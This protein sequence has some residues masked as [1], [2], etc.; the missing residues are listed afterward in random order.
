MLVSRTRHALL[1]ALSYGLAASPAFAQ[2]AQTAKASAP[3]NTTAPNTTAPNTTAPN[4]PTT[5]TA[6]AA[7]L[8]QTKAPQVQ[9]LQLASLLSP[10]LEQVQK[11]FESS[12]QDKIDRV[13]GKEAEIAVAV[14]ITEK[15][16][17][18]T[19]EEGASRSP[20][21]TTG[22]RDLPDSVDYGY[23]EI[24]LPSDDP[25]FAE[26]FDEPENAR[27]RNSAKNTEQA[28]E[29]E[30]MRVS[31]QVTEDLDPKIIESA[32]ALARETLARFNPEIR[33]TKYMPIRAI[34][35]NEA[36][37]NPASSANPTEDKGSEEEKKDSAIEGFKPFLPVLGTVLAAL[38]LTLGVIPIA[39]AVKSSAAA[40]AEAF[41]SMPSSFSSSLNQKNTVNSSGSLGGGGGKSDDPKDKS[42]ATPPPAPVFLRDYARNTRLIQQVLSEAPLTLIQALRDNE[43]ESSGLKWLIPSMN[44]TDQETLKR[45]LGQDRLNRIASSN[46][47]QARDKLVWLQDLVERVLVKR[48]QGGSEV[49][50][51][52]SADDMV[53]LVLAP[54]ALLTQA[55]RQLAT[56]AAWRI[57]VDIL[58]KQ[59]L[60]EFL[61]SFPTEEW[62]V[63]ISASDATQADIQG[64]AQQLFQILSDLE[65]RD[66]GNQKRTEFLRNT[67]L[68]PIVH[69]M[70]NK[71]LTEDETFLSNL[72]RTAPDML[73]LLKKELWTTRDLF[74]VPD[75]FLKQAIMGLS[76][77]Q[78]VS[79]LFALPDAEYARMEKII[80]EGNART[81]AISQ[82]RRMKTKNDPSDIKS[83]TVIG[84][85]FLDY[86]RKES[87][88]GGFKPLA[89]AEVASLSSANG[90][91]PAPAAEQLTETESRAA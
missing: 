80:P 53:R 73:E 64:A 33:V 41:R 37:R 19:P 48:M 16:K 39:R 34:P 5:T 86:L 29:I 88:R 12:L 66:S 50:K 18:V 90:N 36:G 77:E 9:P 7:P 71:P 24:P 89:E 21:A 22:R 20:A 15:Q 4:T 60:E 87:E 51:S 72:S 13:L 6:A 62:S 52:L 74:R 42:G 67:L 44:P 63:V 70:M 68:D 75:D 3:S 81:I 58:E 27:T 11:Q 26:S 14:L 69:L 43:E 79:V 35:K 78:R 45:Y 82:V 10:E 54:T 47:D 32:Q 38:I 76:S 55:V 25:N 83:A 61:A 49:Q 28:L 91:A 8:S 85:Q 30:S 40:L 46:G 1:I 17:V 23:L 65:A 57:L 31:L 84:R 2:Q 59:K 56:P